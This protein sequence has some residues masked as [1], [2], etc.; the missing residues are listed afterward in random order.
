MG[1]GRPA[2]RGSERGVVPHGLDAKRPGV[3]PQRVRGLAD[4]FYTD[5]FAEQSFKAPEEIRK[6][7][8]RGA[9]LRGALLEKTDFYLVDLRD[10]RFDMEQE[11]HFHR[12]GAILE[13]RV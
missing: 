12:C 2:R 3:Q 13:T 9:D 10:A 5:E 7:N 1:A 11:R 8:L 4:R 6:A